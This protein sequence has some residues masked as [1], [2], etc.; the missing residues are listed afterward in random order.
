[1]DV[2]TDDLFVSIKSLTEIFPKVSVDRLVTDFNSEIYIS[3]QKMDMT[4]D[5]AF[6]ETYEGL[7][8]CYIKFVHY[9]EWAVF[10]EYFKKQPHLLSLLKVYGVYMAYKWK[11]ELF[12]E[13]LNR[14]DE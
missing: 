1:M 8:Q 2:T 14:E 12:K 3:L 6:Y 4:K 10:A 13:M 11:I 7:Q 9:N 5:K